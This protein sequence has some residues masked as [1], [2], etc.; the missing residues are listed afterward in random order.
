M[1]SIYLNRLCSNYAFALNDQAACGNV[2]D[3]ASARINLPA[4]IIHPVS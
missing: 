3:R 2:F 4:W 1:K